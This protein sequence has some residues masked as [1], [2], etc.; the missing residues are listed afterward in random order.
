MTNRHAM[1]P[2]E[3]AQTFMYDGSRRQLHKQRASILRSV[4]ADFLRDDPFM[5]L[6]DRFL[7][8][9]LLLAAAE[10]FL[11]QVE[12]GGTDARRP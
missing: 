6:E 12:K 10:R 2:S 4:A 11:P 7:L 9:T 8:A 3:E 1:S 5:P